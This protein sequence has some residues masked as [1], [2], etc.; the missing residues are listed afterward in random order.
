MVLAGPPSIVPRYVPRI[1]DD[2]LRLS[3]LTRRT[4]Y[5]MPDGI[6]TLLWSWNRFS[7]GLHGAIRGYRHHRGGTIVLFE[8]HFLAGVSQEPGGQHG[9][10]TFS[11]VRFTWFRK[12]GC[13]VVA[14]YIS[15]HAR[16]PTESLFDSTGTVGNRLRSLRSG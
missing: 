13:S 4:I 10:T 7:R 5:D 15:Y 14:Q 2:R 16:V 3:S 12:H 8:P 6:S 1:P 9:G 11:N